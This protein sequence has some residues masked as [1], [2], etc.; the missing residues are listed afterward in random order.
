M[1]GGIA[2]SSKWETIEQRCAELEVNKLLLMEEED[3]DTDQIC[4]LHVP[5]SRSQKELKV[6]FLPNFPSGDDSNSQQEMQQLLQDECK[7]VKPDGTV[8]RTLMQRT[9]A[10]PWAAR[11]YRALDRSR[12]SPALA[13][14]PK[15]RSRLVW[16]SGNSCGGEPKCWLHRSASNCG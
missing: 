13:T 2:Y 7:K 16:M 15:K 1:V 10:R 4:P 8:I 6:I 3:Q 12:E 11:V 9:F 14:W 5:A